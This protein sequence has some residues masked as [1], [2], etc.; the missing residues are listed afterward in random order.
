MEEKVKNSLFQ[1]T[2]FI[3]ELL[4]LKIYVMKKQLKIKGREENKMEKDDQ[5]MIDMVGNQMEK[6]E[7]GL[8]NNFKLVH[9]HKLYTYEYSVGLKIIQRKKFM[10][11]IHGKKNLEKY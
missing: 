2:K 5:E 3:V 4:I 11:F 9:V 8:T 10:K 7:E 6:S 1:N